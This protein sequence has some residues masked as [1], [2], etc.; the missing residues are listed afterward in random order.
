MMAIFPDLDT[1]F[2]STFRVRRYQ[3]DGS[4]HP[5]HL[6]YYQSSDDPNSKVLVLTIMLYLTTPE[7]GGGSFLRSSLA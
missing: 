2:Q 7:E 5:P 6:D 1:D 4:Y 3:P